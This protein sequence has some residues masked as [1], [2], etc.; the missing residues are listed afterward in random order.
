MKQR[1]RFSHT[2]YYITHPRI[3][4][5]TL[6]FIFSL[7][8]Q[9]PPW[10]SDTE[11]LTLPF[12]DPKSQCYTGNIFNLSLSSLIHH[13]NLHPTFPIFFANFWSLSWFLN[14]RSRV[15]T[16]SIHRFIVLNAIFVHSLSCKVDLSCFSFWFAIRYA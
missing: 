2:H 1:L 3:H 6:H 7:L 9:I 16:I 4:I 11:G 12:S 8:S 14:D 13:Q 10:N 5:H 15:S